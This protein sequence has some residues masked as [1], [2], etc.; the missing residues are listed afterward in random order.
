MENFSLH[1]SSNPIWLIL[2]ILVFA[3]FAFYIYKFTIPPVSRS[4]RLV[5]ISIRTLALF[6][7]LFLIFEPKFI[8]T[9]KKTI[10]P[11]NY[12]FYDVSR[13]TALYDSVKYDSIINNL[14][15]AF[16]NELNGKKKYFTFSD[17]AKKIQPENLSRLRLNGILTNFDPVFNKLKNS[18]E[19]VSAAVILTDGIYNVGSDPYYSAE[20]RDVPV[21]TIGFGDTS[22]Y[23]DA[24]V[25]QIKR[26]QYIFAGETTAVKALISNSGLE[27]KTVSVSLFEN[28]KVLDAKKI[29]LSLS[30][31]DAVDFEYKPKTAG[32]KRLTVSV[33]PLRDEKIKANNRKSVFVTVLNDK[34]RVS[35]ISGS[36]SADYIFIRDVFRRDKKIK[37]KT[38]TLITEKR[39][40]EK[41]KPENIFD[42]TDVFVLA[43]FPGVNTSDSFAAEVFRKIEFRKA[44][45]FLVLTTGTDLRKLKRLSGFLSFTIKGS[46]ERFE[47]VRLSVIS[48]SSGIFN[49]RGNDPQVWSELPPALQS[50]VSFAPRPGAVVIADAVKGG[51]GTVNP[52]IILERKA[53]QKSIS[54]LGEEIW[55]WKLHSKNGGKFLFDSFIENSIKWLSSPDRKKK[56]IVSSNKKVFVAGEEIYFNAELYDDTF[57]PVNDADVS[58]TVSGKEEKITIPL[59]YSSNGIYEGKI[60]SLPEGDFSFSAT[61]QIDGAFE[62]ASGKFSVVPADLEISD[63]LFRKNLLRQVANV[64]GGI[65][66]SPDSLSAALKKLNELAL[67]NKK[68]KTVIKSI[69]VWSDERILILLVLL[70]SIEWF[71]RK[72]AGML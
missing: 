42:S 53:S 11:V 23:K 6:L 4:L 36:P 16:E 60:P 43:G 12:I 9:N 39:F 17:K 38:L 66:S 35:M 34:L 2:G 71:I 28:G 7:I 58:L 3:A 52:L 68:E 47:S 25:T 10:E 70:F 14:T 26:N 20:Q 30:G 56:L 48:N 72:R 45:Y 37:L 63:L 50:N 24:S 64:S 54:F 57:S 61:A 44:P 8:I 31:V 5:L 1:I 40:I 46:E 19:N 62:K 21:F 27:G 41:E 13:S 22:K 67:V 65:Y 51:G 59:F 33:S 18:R 55:R 15:D 29:T 49:A 32:E 69:D